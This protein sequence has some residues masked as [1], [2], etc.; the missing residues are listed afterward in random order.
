MLQSSLAFASFIHVSF[1]I[2]KYVLHLCAM[3]PGRNIL[4]LLAPFWMPEAQ[5]KW[6]DL[7]GAILSDLFIHRF[8]H[9]KLIALQTDFSSLGFSFVLLQPGNN[10]ASAKAAQDYWDGCGFSFM[11]N[12]STTAL[13]PICFGVH[14]TQGNEVRLHSH[15]GEGFSGDY[16]INKCQQYIFGQ[17]FF[18]VTD[19]YAIKF[20]LS[21]EGSNPAILHLQMHLMCWDVGIVHWPDTELIDANYWSRLG[22]DLD[23]DPL[24]CEY[25]NLTCKL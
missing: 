18:L 21:Y 20:I 3:L 11:M 15:L 9:C 16:A 12:G 23:F 22:V 7:K 10:D 19:C 8:D 6:E 24:F 17:C 1:Q 2:L 13:H 14:H 25:L 5:G 4:M